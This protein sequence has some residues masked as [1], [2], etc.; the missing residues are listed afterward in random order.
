LEEKYNKSTILVG[1]LYAKT[2]FKKIELY[3][4]NLHNLA[5]KSSI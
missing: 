3:V 5:E 2:T 1:E 4:T